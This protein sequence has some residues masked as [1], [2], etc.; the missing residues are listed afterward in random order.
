MVTNY[1]ITLEDF[2]ELINEKS[3]KKGT[4]LGAQSFTCRPFL[5]G[6]MLKVVYD[7]GHAILLSLLFGPT[8]L[9]LG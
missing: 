3:K 6:L 4:N 8:H 1:Y 9:H 2:Q 7:F 5:V